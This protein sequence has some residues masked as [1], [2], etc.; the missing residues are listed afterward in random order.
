MTEKQDIKAKAWELTLMYTGPKYDAFLSVQS[1]NPT[2]KLTVED[3][4]KNFKQISDV[5]EKLITEE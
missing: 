3:H 1:A 2:G 5:F 4:I